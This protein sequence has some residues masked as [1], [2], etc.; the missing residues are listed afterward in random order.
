VLPLALFGGFGTRTRRFGLGFPLGRIALSIG[1]VLLGLALA[2]Q[3]ITAGDISANL[4]DL[5]LNAFDDSLDPFF[6]SAVLIP[7]GSVLLLVLMN[8]RPESV[9]S[10]GG[11]EPPCAAAALDISSSHDGQRVRA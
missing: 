8:A 5:A 3:V 10:L 7:H 1:L 2:D 11:C 9:R 4:F 6:G